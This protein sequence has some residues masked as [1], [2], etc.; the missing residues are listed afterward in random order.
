MLRY[1]KKVC[2]GMEFI[3][4]FNV[5]SLKNESTARIHM[6]YLF[7]END[8]NQGISRLHYIKILVTIPIPKLR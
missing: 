8:L 7:Q 6:S 1:V 2:I 4:K 5:P 3:R